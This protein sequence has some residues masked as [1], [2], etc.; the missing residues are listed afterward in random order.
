MNV[1]RFFSR[2]RPYHLLPLSQSNLVFG[3][4]VVAQKERGKTQTSALYKATALRS[5]QAT[6]K[7]NAPPA[8]E[9]MPDQTY[10]GSLSQNGNW[11]M[12]TTSMTSKKPAQRGRTCLSKYIWSLKDKGMVEDTNYSI[13]WALITRA[14]SFSPTSGQCRLCLM[15][16]SLLVLKPHL[17]SLN[18]RDEFFC[19][20]RHKEKLLLQAIKWKWKSHT[21]TTKI[22]DMKLTLFVVVLF[23]FIPLVYLMIG[24]TL[25][26]QLVINEKWNTDC[27]ILQI[28]IQ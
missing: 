18:D 23:C 3:I 16:K 6:V 15:E 5:Y 20:C 24:S 26:N 8:E 1:T 2:P 14:S 7:V 13:S 9:Q 10:L 17:G 11:D 4:Y 27:F 21:Y 28:Y 22:F 25:W 19:H 12:P